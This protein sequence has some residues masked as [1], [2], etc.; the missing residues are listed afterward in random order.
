MSVEFDAPAHVRPP[1]IRRF[2][3]SD[4]AALLALLDEAIENDV[5][6]GAMPAAAGEAPGD[7]M[8]VGAG[9]ARVALVDPTPRTFALARRL[10]AAGEPWHGRS[11]IWFAPEGLANAGGRLAIMFPG[12]EPS[13]EIGQADIAGLCAHVGLAVPDIDDSTI[14]HRSSAIIRLGLLFDTILRR[15]GVVPDLVM[16]HSLG[17]WTATAASGMVPASS[18]PDLISGL[19]LDN[20]ELP[21]VDFGAL[22]ASAEAAR[23]ALVNTTGVVISHDNCSRQSV[24]CG[25]PDALDA[26]LDTLRKANI[27]GGRLHLR[28]G[29]HT[30]AMAP[31][32][33]PVRDF[34][35]RLPLAA[36]KLPM[37]SATTCDPYPGTAEDIRVLHLRHLVEPVRYR[38]LVERLHAEGVRIFVQA[39]TGSLVGFVDDTLSDHDHFAVATVTA[40]RSALAQLYRVLTG[41]WVEGCPV[42]PS[43]LGARAVAGG[44]HAVTPT[45]TSS[46]PG[47]TVISV[48]GLSTATIT[49]S[50][51][52]E[53][54]SD[55]ARVPA[56]ASPV[57]PRLSLPNAVPAR[58]PVTTP[59][60]TAVAA[61]LA[62]ISQAVPPLTTAPA[63]DVENPVLAA[64]RAV[65]V[66]A[67]AASQDVLTVWQTQPPAGPRSVRQHVAAVRGPRRSSPRSR[68][69]VPGLGSVPQPSEPKRDG[70]PMSPPMP[71]RVV[72]AV[73]NDLVVATGATEPVVVTTPTATTV[74]PVPAATPAAPIVDP[75][76]AFPQKFR[77]VKTL[78]VELMPE[79]LDHAL[80]AQPEGWTNHHDIFPVVPLTAQIAELAE[81]AAIHAP[82]RIVKTLDKLRVF[83]W[84]D[85]AAEIDLDVDATFDSAD[86]ARVSF[87]PHAKAHAHLADAYPE[88]D[89]VLAPALS[90]E[91]PTVHDA[92]ELFDQM[93]MFHGPAYHGVNRLGPM[94]DDG[95]RAELVALPARGATLDN[96]GKLV[97]YW[98][99]EQRGWGES[100]FPIGI[101]R[102]DF[103]G[104][105]LPDG[106]ILEADV[107]ITAF[108][109]D[110]VKA[111]GDLFLTD[112]THWCH[113]EGWQAH[114]FAG[115]DRV[116]PVLRFPRYYLAAEPQP[117]GWM[118]L[119]ERWPTGAARDMVARRYLSQAERQEYERQN[120]REQRTWLLNRIVAKDAVRRWLADRDIQAFPIEVGVT[121]EADGRITVA[122]PHLGDHDLRVAV[123]HVEWLSVAV[124]AEG[125]DPCIDLVEVTD[126]TAP[127]V[128][129]VETAGL[130]TRRIVLDIAE[131]VS[132]AGHP[133]AVT[134][135]PAEAATPGHIDLTRESAA[136][137]S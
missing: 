112:G 51:S 36:P 19:D 45:P 46:A 97:A 61:P 81:A 2:A 117:G 49:M 48:G 38:E 91:R 44:P 84:L 42:D 94:A 3:A 6:V 83:R 102:I 5:A 56:A 26:A 78:S 80:M 119:R 134:W 59:A 125:V 79:V 120:L 85:I 110:K 115:D 32:L 50:R 70:R 116:S 63:S 66:E 14:G 88:S 126:P 100:A 16:G 1:V 43:T 129:C 92:R 40:K 75:S 34:L 30:P 69:T 74:A 35:D 12:V 106:T 31:Y 29:F 107:R 4:A 122:S 95:I 57:P 52:L 104:A 24:I 82:G 68:A 135:G 60:A 39:G 121:T 118:L 101:D 65:F 47:P 15:V 76:G 53:D 22:G 103:F 93:L 127:P 62:A 108:N 67:A 96:V 25:E 33:Q 136:V 13:F 105:E 137:C 23:A 89:I 131:V 64:A 71:P 18:V 58:A 87:G 111:N 27:M 113:I 90:N 55:L 37:W 114:I 73:A 28:S 109:G 7:D 17:E 98:V 41:L 21:P 130:T 10:V 77:R 20:I 72:P 99:M 124:L 128:S 123:A 54:H 86:M 11:D 133:L 9:P 132:A 8:V